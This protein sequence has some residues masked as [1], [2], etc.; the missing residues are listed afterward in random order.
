MACGV[1]VPGA[2]VVATPCVALFRG[3]QTLLRA[4]SREWT[5][6][7]VVPI[8]CDA[9]PVGIMPLSSR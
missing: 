9:A 7:R 5:P 1:S 2:P 4:A 8:F 3:R 6:M